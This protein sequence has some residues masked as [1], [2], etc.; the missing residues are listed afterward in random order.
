MMVYREPGAGSVHDAPQA[1]V[2]AAPRAAI[3]EPRAG[4]VHDAPAVREPAAGSAVANRRCRTHDNMREHTDLEYASRVVQGSGCIQGQSTTLPKIPDL[5]KRIQ[6][7]S[8]DHLL[9]H[10]YQG[11]TK[12]KVPG[13]CS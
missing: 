1:A 9:D 10:F 5:M 8:R 7:R 13:R 2:A 4:S 6:K 11:Q 12:V 3:R